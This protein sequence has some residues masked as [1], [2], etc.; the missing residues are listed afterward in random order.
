MPDLSS[1]F[2]AGSVTWANALIAVLIVVAAFILS[3][4][5]KK[6]VNALSARVPG[7]HPEVISLTARIVKYAVIL[8]GIGLALAMLGAN[9]QPVLAAVIIIA[10]IGVIAVR[11]VATNFGA[12]VII[13]ARRSIHIGQWIEVVGILGQVQEMNSRS[14]V[15]VTR[16]GRTVHLP[17]ATVLDN[18]MINHSESG[19]T[20][21][22][23]EV[24]VAGVDDLLTVRGVIVGAAGHA[25]G[26][27]SDRGVDVSVRSVSPEGATF[28]LRVWHAPLADVGVAS[29]VVTAVSEALRGIGVR[30]TVVG[31]VPTLPLTPPP[32]L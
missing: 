5:A 23:L 16:D 27:L 25:P 14:V 31:S 19:A 21:T 2:S 29:E 1:L 30:S 12:A 6:G 10:A 13:Q 22:A 11:G 26:V 32:A 3:H 15:V 24:R 4:F 20:R 9:V 7:L 8:F 18:P 17:N 28:E